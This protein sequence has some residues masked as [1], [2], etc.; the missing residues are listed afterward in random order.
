MA[1][2]KISRKQLLNE[3]DEF[4]T[5]SHRMIQFAIAHRSRLLAVL[6]GVVVLVFTL[7]GIG[8]V[9]RRAENKAF[10]LL[11]KNVSQYQMALQTNG[12]Q[13]AYRAV[14]KEFST[15]VDNY[16][17]RQGGKLAGLHLADICFRAGEFDRALALYEKAQGN[18]EGQPFYQHLI[19]NCLGYVHQSRQDYDQAIGFFEKTATAAAAELQ[20]EALFNLGQLYARTG[21][22]QKRVEVL[23]KILADHSESIYVD[24]VREDLES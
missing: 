8:Y 4:L 19:W 1:K 6:I 12:A 16:A 20:A 5:L 18:F 13:E 7:A 10:A 15:L 11:Q 24:I 9:N 22:D 14:E 3:P 17:R 21:R 2:S 23:K